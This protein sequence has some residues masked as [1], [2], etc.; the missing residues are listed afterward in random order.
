MHSP[1]Y[2]KKPSGFSLEREG[3]LIAPFAYQPKPKGIKTLC[4][5]YSAKYKINLQSIDMRG[6]IPSED[7][8][9]TL[10]MFTHLAKNPSLI[11]VEEGQSRGLILNHGDN[12]AIPLLISKKENITSIVC[13]DSTAG[14]SIKG[15]YKMANALSACQFYLNEG[16]RQADSTSCI[17]DSICILKEALQIENLMNLI[18]QNIYQNHRGLA[19]SRFFNSPPPANF[20]L[21]KV[22]EQLLV[23]AQL[24]SYVKDSDMSVILRGGKTLKDYRSQF[25][26]TFS[27]FKGSE[28]K[29]N[30]INSYLYIK[31]AEHRGIFDLLEVKNQEIAGYLHLAS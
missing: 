24:P 18:D 7:Y 25:C 3:F 19:P 30:D 23:T 16:S 20:K 13:F 12:H 6:P 26:I 14:A 8:T 10:Q 11:D 27:I 29:I 17:T 2:K 28:I 22:P 15:Y 1:F 21:F 9:N 4:A 5:Y 31:S